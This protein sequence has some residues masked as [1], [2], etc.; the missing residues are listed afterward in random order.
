MDYFQNY[1][2]I[3]IILLFIVIVVGAMGAA[4]YLFNYFIVKEL[5]IMN[6]YLRHLSDILGYNLKTISDK[7]GGIV[8]YNPNYNQQR[9]NNENAENT[10]KPNGNGLDNKWL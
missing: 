3:S 8:T 6:A 9:I 1:N 10:N 2:G 7:T 4:G 5:K